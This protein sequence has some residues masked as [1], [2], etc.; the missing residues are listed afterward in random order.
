MTTSSDLTRDLLLRIKRQQSIAL[1]RADD[2]INRLNAQI[3]AMA[4]L[5][6]HSCDAIDRR[7]E[8]IASLRRELREAD[9]AVEWSANA[10][11]LR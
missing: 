1:E 9:A 5:L 8:T 2:R 11:G 4:T 6:E 7:D 10:E 3:G